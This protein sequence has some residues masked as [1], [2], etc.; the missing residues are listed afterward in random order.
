MKRRNVKRGHMVYEVMDC[1]NL[2]YPDN[3]F[4]VCIDKST[5]DALLCGDNAFLNTAIM[6][7]EGQRVLKEDGGVYIAISYGK[8]ST[9][10][11]HFERPFLSWSLQE[12][13]FHPAEVPDAQESEEK[14]HYLYICAK[15]RN[16]KQV[17]QE[18]FE[19][20]I[21]QLI[22]HEKNV[23]A[24]RDLEEEQDKDLDASTQIQLDLERAKTEQLFSRPK[25][26]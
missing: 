23:N 25:S 24:G 4:D 16:W 11:F 9:R 6:L 20:V 21:L 7:K 15:Q 14:A 26:A 18:N 8:P 22:L 5:I 1:C 3:Y 17:Y 19:P 10:S 2:K 12:R 13:V